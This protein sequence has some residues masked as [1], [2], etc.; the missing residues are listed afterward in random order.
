[1]AVIREGLET[2]LFLVGQATSDRARGRVDPRRCRSSAWRSRSL[3]RLRLLPR[4]PAPQPRRVLPLDRHRARL[5][6]RRPAE[7]RHRRVHRDRRARLRPLDGDRFDISGVLSDEQGIGAFL[8][9]IFGYSA[10]PAVLTS[11][12]TSPTWSPSWPSTS[13]R[14]GGPRRSAPT[15]RRRSVLTRVVTGRSRDVPRDDHRPGVGGTVRVDPDVA[16]LRLGVVSS[17]RRPPRPGRRRGAMQAIL[18]GADRGGVERRDLR[19]TLVGLDAVRDYSP[20]SGPR[21]T[22]YQLTNTVEA[23][24]RAIDTVGGADRRRRSA[25]GATSMD[26]LSFRLA[27]PTAALAEA[28]RRAVADARVRA[29]TLAA[30]AGVTARTRRGASSR[31]V[32]CRPDRRGRWRRSRLKA[33]V[34]RSTRRSRR[35]R[36]SWHDR[37]TVDASRSPDGGA[38]AQRVVAVTRRSRAAADVGRVQLARLVLAERREVVVRLAT[39]GRLAV[40]RRRP[41]RSPRPVRS[42]SRR[43]VAA[44]EGRLRRARGTRRRR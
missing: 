25:A 35:A 41:G 27:D 23:T 3:H 40:A 39:S 16:T 18:D 26:G 36:A 2:S 7:P 34:R 44:G 14:C 20:E 11:S 12:P 19:T 38:S 5:H 33:A 24:I 42:S 32:R 21:V 29:T 10:A 4:Q 28:R 17:D 30:E 1:M 15:R 13:G 22:G 43:T 8:R 9:A 6:R 31:A 37:L